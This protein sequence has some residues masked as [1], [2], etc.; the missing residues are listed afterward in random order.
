MKTRYLNAGAVLCLLLIIFITPIFPGFRGD[1][2]CWID[3]ADAIRQHG[4]PNVYDSYTNYLPVYHYVLWLFAQLAPSREFLIEHVYWL[5]YVTLAVDIIGLLLLYHWTD[6]KIPFPLILIISLLNPGYMYDNIVFGQVD[7][8]LAT[9]AFATLY[10]AY[11][12][13]IIGAAIL[14]SIMI[15]FKLQGIV[16]FPIYGLLLL[17]QNETRHWLKVILKSIV[18]LV[19][20]E[21]II[22]LPFLLK[23]DGLQ[24]VLNTITGLV[25]FFP[26]TSSF[27]FNLW[28]FIL[29]S[30]A[31]FTPDDAVF[32]LGLSYKQFGL[33]LFF[34]SSFFALWPLLSFIY[35][36]RIQ[37]KAISFPKEQ[38]WLIAA[39]I[40]LVFFFFNT[41]MHDRYSYPAFI[42]IAAYSF[43]RKVFLAYILFSFAVVMN[44]EFV[45]RWLNLDNYGTVIFDRKLIAPIFAIVI[46][47][48]YYQLYKTYF[49]AQKAERLVKKSEAQLI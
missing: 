40:T 29:G 46:F 7:G 16:F 47:Y 12:Q 13:K 19:V 35:K 10:C 30:K 8:I 48:L 41:Q 1:I 14:F 43:H 49:S 6:R 23:P 37:H 2:Y 38:V 3:W 9:L 31:E 21:V 39:L 20:V 15:N 28:A 42:F 27:A 33:I 45:V 5:R 26:T 22:L 36:K 18:V 44:L 34:I 4:L 25:G 17:A 32:I 24:Q 11:N